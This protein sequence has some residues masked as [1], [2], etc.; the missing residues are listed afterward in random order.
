M[1]EA[2]RSTPP[3]A[4]GP[5]FLVLMW[6]GTFFVPTAISTIAD[7]IL[8]EDYWTGL[9]SIFGSLRLVLKQMV[10]YENPGFGPDAVVEELPAFMSWAPWIVF[11]V[12][13]VV[14]VG[15][16]HWRTRDIEEVV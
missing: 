12:L 2:R 3:S 1:V 14:S 9:L 6:I 7:L 10:G 8:D 4:V 16:I 15:V 11:V 13:A 5:M